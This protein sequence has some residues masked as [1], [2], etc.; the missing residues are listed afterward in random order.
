MPS[1]NPFYSSGSAYGNPTGDLYT[2]PFV[3]DYLSPVTSGAEFEKFLTDQGY[4][5]FNRQDQ[6]ARSQYGRTQTG[7]K[8]ALLSNPLLSERDYLSGLGGGFFS[9]IW[10]ALTPSQRGEQPNLWSGRA[11]MIGRG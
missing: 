2:S 3:R 7:Y 8:A 9:N 1:S 11:R 6:F 5:G 4:G 10:N